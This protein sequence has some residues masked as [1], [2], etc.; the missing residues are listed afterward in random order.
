MMDAAVVPLGEP[1]GFPLPGW[2][3]SLLP[4]PAGGSGFCVTLAATSPSPSPSSSSFSFF[5][6]LLLGVLALN[7]RRLAVDLMY[8]FSAESH[9][10]QTKQS[11]LDWREHQCKHLI[12]IGSRRALRFI[13]DTEIEAALWRRL[14]PAAPRCCVPLLELQVEPSDCDPHPRDRLPVGDVPNHHLESDH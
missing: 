8:R 14:P 4:P 11:R 12:R 2:S 10:P 13:I 5:L 6:L 1:A 3:R 9:S 7:K